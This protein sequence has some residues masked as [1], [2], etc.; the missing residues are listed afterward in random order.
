VPPSQFQ[1]RKGSLYATPGSRDTHHG[2]ADRD[3]AYHEKLKE[4]VRLDSTNKPFQ[5]AKLTFPGMGNSR[6]EGM[7]NEKQ[8]I[9]ILWHRQHTCATALGW[10]KGNIWGQRTN[11]MT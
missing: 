5:S 9:A 4:K 8:T 3:K 1:K 6:Q 10:D 7:K 2:N 11:I